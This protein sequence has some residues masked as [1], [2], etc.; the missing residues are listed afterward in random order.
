ML[1]KSFF[2]SLDFSATL[3]RKRLVLIEVIIRYMM[4]KEEINDVKLVD[5]KRQLVDPLTKATAPS[6]NLHNVLWHGS[7]NSLFHLTEG[8]S[9]VFSPIAQESKVQSQVESYQRLKKWYLTPPCLTLSILRYWSRVE[10]SNPGKGVAP[11]STLWC[12]S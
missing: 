9:A 12:C 8:V 4:V 2:D 7:I 10:G 5:K 6:E 1:N 11:F 3:E